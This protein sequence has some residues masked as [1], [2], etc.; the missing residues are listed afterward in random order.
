MNQLIINK[1]AKELIDFSAF[2]YK[3]AETDEKLKI[4][5]SAEE[6]IKFSA[7]KIFMS[8]YRPEILPNYSID[9]IAA[10]DF[11][12]NMLDYFPAYKKEIHQMLD[13]VNKI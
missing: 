7:V 3:C 12:F 1:T 6:E 11:L 5:K 13:I 2:V 8:I 10:K 9:K 4:S